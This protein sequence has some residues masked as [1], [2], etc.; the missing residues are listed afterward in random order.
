MT[1]NFDEHIDRTGT[2]SIKFES[3][4]LAEVKNPIP[5]WIADMDFACPQPVLDAM[6]ARLDRRIL[7]YSTIDDPA[8]YAAVTGWMQ[9][10]H[11]WTVDPAS[12]VFADGIVTALYEAVEHL[13]K[14]GD[15]IMM[16]TPS[17]GPFNAA[18]LRNGRTPVYNKL[19]ERS[20]YY[21]IDFD[22]LEKQASDPSCTLLFLCSPQN[23]TGRVWTEAELRRV[24]EICFANNVFVVSDEIHADLVR[25]NQTHIPFATLF[26]DEKRLMTCTAPSK[27]FNLAGNRHSNLIIPD[28]VIA[29]EWKKASYC[30]HPGPL[31]IDATIAA[32]NL[33]E[34]WLDALR[35]YLDE[36]FAFLKTYF[37]E[38]LPKAVFSIPEGTYLAWVD[39]SA[40]G[41]TD[42]DLEA[43]VSRTGVIVEFSDDFVADTEGHMRINCACPRAVLAEAMRRLTAAIESH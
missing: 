19:I 8:Y 20:G 9:R 26:P 27:T 1:F 6:H 35:A 42:G 13:T 12:I 10:R 5:L 34:D 31:S 38:H 18:V 28:P 14:P 21:T 36:N 3:S 15:R 22:L 7:G 32:Y 25:L 4:R 2:H 23:P 16:M 37:A 43:A 24:G 40:Y 33:C 17:Y 11:G 29:S 30:G 39:A 41:M